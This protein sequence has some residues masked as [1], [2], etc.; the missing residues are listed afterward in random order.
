MPASPDPALSTECPCTS[1][2]R[3]VVAS[4]W[5]TDVHPARLVLHSNALPD[6]AR[7]V[8]ADAGGVIRE[9]DEVASA[10]AAVQAGMRVRSAFTPTDLGLSRADAVALRLRGRGYDY[11]EVGLTVGYSVRHVRR[12]LAALEDQTGLTR[13]EL[14]NVGSVIA[15]IDDR[16]ASPTSMT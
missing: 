7:A 16:R 5:R 13:D 8:T 10:L 12:R 15:Y 4:R 9:D 6:V 14:V 3:V 2:A 1:R 11:T